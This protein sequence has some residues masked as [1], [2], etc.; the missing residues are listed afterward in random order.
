MV[1]FLQ[2]DINPIEIGKAIIRT[3]EFV[4]DP[5]GTVN[6]YLRPENYAE[7]VEMEGRQPVQLK[8]SQPPSTSNP[9]HDD[10]PDDSSNSSD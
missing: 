4:I 1:H 3:V 8:D 7:P 9:E 5:Y 10:S 2:K 6:K